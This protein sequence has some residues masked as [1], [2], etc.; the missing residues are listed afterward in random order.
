M[1]S[2]LSDMTRC[3]FCFANMCMKKFLMIDLAFYVLKMCYS[4]VIIRKIKFLFIFHHDMHH[5][6]V[7]ICKVAKMHFNVDGFSL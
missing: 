3:L 5:N 7:I 4:F 1:T 6:N 2:S